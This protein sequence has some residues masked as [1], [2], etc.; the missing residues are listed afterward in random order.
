MNLTCGKLRNWNL[1][2]QEQKDLKQSM[3]QRELVRHDTLANMRKT[4]KVV[5]HCKYLSKSQYFALIEMLC[6]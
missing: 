6:E 5:R 3:I 1:T 2:S 4:K